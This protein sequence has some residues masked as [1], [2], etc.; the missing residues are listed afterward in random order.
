MFFYE[1]LFFLSSFLN[2]GNLEIYFELE[3]NM[4]NDFSYDLVDMFLKERFLFNHI[5]PMF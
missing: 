4:W 1:Y 5:F 2:L 3:L